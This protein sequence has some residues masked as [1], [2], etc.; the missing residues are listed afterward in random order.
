MSL[1]SK[2]AN[3]NKKKEEMIKINEKL[4]MQEAYSWMQGDHTLKIVLVTK[5]VTSIIREWTQMVKSSSN[6]PKATLTKRRSKA[7]IIL[8]M[9]LMLLMIILLMFLICLIMNLMH[10]MFSW[11][12]NW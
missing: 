4:K 7:S 6:S 9:F 11:E 10:P 5:V 12:K 1:H 3:I 8:S 2:M